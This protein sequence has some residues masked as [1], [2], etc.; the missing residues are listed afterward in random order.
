VRATLSPARV[1]AT[2]GHAVCEL[3]VAVD[4]LNAGGETSLDF[5]AIAI[6]LADRHL[7]PMRD[8]VLQRVQERL[9]AVV[10]HGAMRH[11]QHAAA[12]GQF[13]ARTHHRAGQQSRPAAGRSAARGMPLESPLRPPSRTTH[14]TLKARQAAN[15]CNRLDRERIM[16]CV[17]SPPPRVQR[18]WH[19]RQALLAAVISLAL[20]G[21]ASAF[22]Q[23]AELPS[24]SRLEASGAVIRSVL[25]AP[26]PIFDESRPGE[27]TYLF[28]LANRLHIDTAPSVIRAQLLFKEGD[29]YSARVLRETERNLRKLRFLREP[30]VRVVRVD[31][32]QVDLEV[33]T[34]DVWTLSPTLEFGRSGGSNKSSVGLQDFNFLGYGKSIEL[35]H[36]SDRD[37]TS[38]VVA[39]ND[40]NLLGSRWRLDFELSDLSDGHDFAAKVERPFFALD[41][42]SSYSL[43]VGDADLVQRRYALGEEVDSYRRQST[44]LDGFVGFSGG[45]VD[46]WST[47][48]SVG[49]RV[50]D[51][52]FS[53]HEPAPGVAPPADRDLRYPYY[54]F[55]A[56]EDDFATIINRDTIG[57]TEDEVYGRSYLAE[58]GF[59]ASSFGS[60]RNAVMLRTAVADGFRLSTQQSL[61][62]RAQWSTRLESGRPVDELFG[63]GARY[64]YRQSDHS[65]F[66]AGLLADAGHRLDADHDLTLGG[67]NGLRAYDIAFQSGEKRALL[68]LEQRYFSDLK[69]FRTFTVG[70]AAFADIGRVWGPNSIDAPNLG[71]L[72]DV[73]IGLRFGNLRSARA[74]VLHVDLAWPLDDPFNSG[75][76]LMIETRSSF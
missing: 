12:F 58:I 21:H 15:V 73:G 51:A 49:L 48:H 22:A 39:Y 62:V 54:R 72:R 27:R 24:D 18:S 30:A 29:R 74:N 57:R 13:D 76:Q 60:D 11:R 31:G 32:N 66:Y 52:R 44:Q 34:T 42:H 33:V 45:L 37:R 65:T 61:F 17:E 3:V 43:S 25:I 36:K 8:A 20:A 38:N 46:G 55:E 68:T 7:D 71:T 5:D 63:V 67:D 6:V 2:A 50:D 40:P 10:E 23:A 53:P 70:A 59:A 64:F 9:L 28:R 14:L 35:S 41:T 75:P 16:G 19:R 56:I 69:I 4:D 1:T 26:Q 47:R